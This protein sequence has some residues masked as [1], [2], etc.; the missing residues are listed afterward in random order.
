MRILSL[1]ALTLLLLLLASRAS[2]AERDWRFSLDGSYEYGQV[3]GYAQ[4][5]AGGQ[6]GTTSPKRPSL[7]EIG[8]DDAS[9]Y[10]MRAIGAWRDEELSLDAQ[11][12]RLSG[13]NTLAAPLTSQGQ[14]FPAG[15]AVSSDVDLDWYSLAYR[16]RFRIGDDLVLTPSA[17]GLLWTFHYRLDSATARADRSYAKANGA[18]GLEAQWR[19]ND[20]RFAVD[21]RLLGT[22]PIS[23]LANV[24]SE[25]L[26]ASY[27]VIQRRDLSIGVVGGVGFEQM[28]YKDSQPLPNH[29]HAEFGPMFII[30]IDA[31]F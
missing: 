11:I 20:G 4:T 30:G 24:F 19:P 29:V 8:I 21:L 25:Q 6:P 17:G 27:D 2:A 3:D 10:G 13:D 7:G 12:I 15:T 28:D 26:L 23:G 16:H 9:I 22:P 31:R 14:S 5:P 1:L 18:L